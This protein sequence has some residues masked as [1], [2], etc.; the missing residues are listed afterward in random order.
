MNRQAFTDVFILRWQAGENRK[1]CHRVIRARSN[2]EAKS[3]EIEYSSEGYHSLAEMIISLPPKRGCCLISDDRPVSC[4]CYL[5]FPPG[6]C[7]PSMGATETRDNLKRSK[8]SARVRRNRP[9][10]FDERNQRIGPE[11]DGSFSPVKLI[12]VAYSREEYFITGGGG[13]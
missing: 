3:A 2:V 5:S 11:S 4:I 9:C 7:A 6:S 10:S 8:D 1:H 12:S 13:G